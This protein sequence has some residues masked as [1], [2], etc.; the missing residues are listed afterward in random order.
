MIPKCDYYQI[1]RE[2]RKNERDR[3][4]SD[5]G[6]MGYERMG[7]YECDGYNERCKSYS[8]LKDRWRGNEDIKR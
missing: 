7:C 4:L 3:G 1:A 5:V 6:T 2:Q 8:N